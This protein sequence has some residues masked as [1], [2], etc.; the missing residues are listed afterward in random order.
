MNDENLE[1]YAD[2]LTKEVDLIL[3]ND[4]VID[5]VQKDKKSANILCICSLGCLALIFMLRWPS[6]VWNMIA[7]VNNITF[8]YYIA[9]FFQ[10]L[11]PISVIASIV[12][13]VVARKKYPKSKF[14]KVL[15]W[16]YIVIFGLFFLSYV[17]V[18][19]NLVS[20]YYH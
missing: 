4:A 19:F 5:Q 12:L 11:R 3:D 14:A 2:N 13:M 6:S 1:Q 15:M 8:P 7:I 17:L 16:I 10:K 18:Q 20:Y 9:L